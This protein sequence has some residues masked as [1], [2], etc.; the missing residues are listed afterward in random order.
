ME[1][2]LH[3][4]DCE[5]EAEFIRA[6]R[7]VNLSPAAQARL[8]AALGVAAGV[9]AAE[10]A[11]STSVLGKLLASKGLIAAASM[12]SIGAIGAGVYWSSAAEG[13]IEQ[14]PSVRVAE[15]VPQS[16]S[17]TAPALGDRGARRALSKRWWMT[18][19]ARWEQPAGPERSTAYATHHPC[20][21]RRRL[22]SARLSM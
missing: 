2:L 3:P 11:A 8:L 7:D 6:G 9:T 20:S 12:I 4:Q 16:P 5:L 14:A 1:P 10:A 22:D 13:P 15:P 17:Q 19:T 18:A 21:A